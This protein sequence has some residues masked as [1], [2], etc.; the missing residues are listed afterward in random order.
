MVSV[1]FSYL[2]AEILRDR[3]SRLLSIIDGRLEK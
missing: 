3:I 1:S 2:D